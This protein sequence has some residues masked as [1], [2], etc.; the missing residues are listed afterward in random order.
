MP[1][2]RQPAHHNCLMN[3]VSQA[4]ITAILGT[5]DTL[6]VDERSTLNSL[7]AIPARRASPSV[8]PMTMTQT[9]AARLL[10]VH[11]TTLW[12]SRILH[13]H[14]VAPGIYRYSREEIEKVAREGFHKKA[15]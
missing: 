15:S 5:D 13:A 1:E 3:K 2:F 8:Q 6:S 4:T 12:R 7:L 9:A 14:E 11:R 10:G